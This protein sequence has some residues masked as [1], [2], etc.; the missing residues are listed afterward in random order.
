M[1]LKNLDQY[2]TYAENNRNKITK[3]FLK[4]V[5]AIYLILIPINDL[6]VVFA[7]SFIKLF[8]LDG[9]VFNSILYIKFVKKFGNSPP[10]ILLENIILFKISKTAFLS[11]HLN[12]TPFLLS[13]LNQTGFFNSPEKNK[14]QQLKKF[15]AALKAECERKKVAFDPEEVENYKKFLDLY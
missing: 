7:F 14:A 1:K 6:E 4:P 3:I 5:F 8:L 10:N 15:E 13:H 2:I 12:K 11:K 9:L